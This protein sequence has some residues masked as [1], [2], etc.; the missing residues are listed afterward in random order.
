M[1]EVEEIEEIEEIYKFDYVNG[2]MFTYNIH[3]YNNG[4]EW[5]EY[6]KECNISELTHKELCEI[7]KTGR[8]SS[9]QNSENIK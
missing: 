4:N 2:L 7:W 5:R 6:I 9:F 8:A 3:K 1:S